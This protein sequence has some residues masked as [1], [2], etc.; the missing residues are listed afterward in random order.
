MERRAAGRSL[1]VMLGFVTVLGAATLFGAFNSLPDGSRHPALGGMCLK[2]AS[3]AEPWSC[4]PGSGF[5]V[6]PNVLVSCAHAKPWLDQVKPL[7]IG[8]TFDEKYSS[9]PLVYEVQALHAD[10][11]FDLSNPDDPHDLAVVILKDE[12]VDIRPVSLPP[13]LN[14]LDRG[15]LAF[16]TFFTLVDRAL[17]TWD[18]FPETPAWGDRQYG[19]AVATDLRSGVI[20]IGP[21]AKHPV[22]PCVG[23]SGSMALL[24]SSRIAVGVGSAFF[25][26]DMCASGFAYTRLDTLQARDF[27]G[28]F[29]PAALLPR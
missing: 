11:D 27:L 20:M 29:L 22:Q 23:S 3:D 24:A 2:F 18:G 16:G 9:N 4:I 26:G 21:D 1:A 15:N 19:R 10:P 13:V 28:N 17:T 12:V 6:A 7:R 14:M 5:L 8:F 25:E